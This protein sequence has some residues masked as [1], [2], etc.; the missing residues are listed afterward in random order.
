M[1]AS[2][3]HIGGYEAASSE[4]LRERPRRALPLQPDLLQKFYVLMRQSAPLLAIVSLWIGPKWQNPEQFGHL[5]AVPFTIRH[6]LIVLVLMMA[7]F[8]VFKLRNAAEGRNSPRL[9]FITS[10]ITGV[11]TATAACTAILLGGRVILRHPGL[12]NLSLTGFALRCSA[13][14]VACVLTGAVLYSVAYY[15]SRPKLYLIVGSRKKAIAA[16][17]RLQHRGAHRGHVLGF[18]DPDHSHAKYLPS[19][20]LGSIDKLES[21][22][23]WQPVDMVYLALPLNSHYQ[24]VQ[25][26]IRICERIGVEYSFS[27]DVF[28]TR[29]SR[30]SRFPLKQVRGFVYHVAHEDYEILLKRAVDL[31]VAT[32]LL[33]LLSP[34]MLTIALA[35]KLTSSGPVFFTQ[36]RYG[37]NRRRFRIYKFRS[38]VADAE[39]LMNSIESLNEAQGPIFKI[40]KD[41][42]ITKVGRLL[43]RMSLDELPQLFNVITGDMSLVGPRPMSL[44]DVQRFSEGSLMRRFSVMPGITGLCQVSGRSNTD[45]DTWIRLDLQ[46]IDQW[47]P[48]L[49]FRILL[50]TIPAVLSGRGA[51]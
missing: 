23:M 49:D 33:C 37:R 21:I 16:Y 28:E 44:R 31:L 18:L 11:L 25:E 30:A 12:T 40:R 36:E 5:M 4:S 8:Q 47:S 6:V 14:G 48:G 2:T 46:Y 19:D 38:M 29:L 22:L 10:Q 45:F 32:L 3:A 27:A 41:P 39:G 17:K 7:W 50:R 35:V 51:V 13:I 15:V 26:A 34:L 24:T 43:R 20:Y 9:R 42:R 1:S